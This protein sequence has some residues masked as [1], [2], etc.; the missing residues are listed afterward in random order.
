MTLTTLTMERAHDAAMARDASL[1]ERPSRRVF[2]AEYKLHILTE[3][4][5]ATEDGG[6]GAILR[7]EGLYSSHI[8]EWRRARDAGALAGLAQKPRPRTSTPE[9]MELARLR[10]VARPHLLVCTNVVAPRRAEQRE[11]AC[12]RRHHTPPATAPHG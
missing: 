4:E 12:P 11:K 7:R 10:R 5:A 9:Q 8:V 2:G 1:P 6:R 3:Y